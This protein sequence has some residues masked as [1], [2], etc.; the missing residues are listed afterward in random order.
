MIA[1]S[2]DAVVMRTAVMPGPAADLAYHLDV[3][4]GVQPGREQ[5]GG[6]IAALSLDEPRT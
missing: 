4:P 5:V 3:Q 1:I 2:P 6:G